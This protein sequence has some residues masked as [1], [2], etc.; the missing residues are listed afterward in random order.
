MVPRPRRRSCRSR[1]PS[2]AR[3]VHVRVHPTPSSARGGDDLKVDPGGCRAADGRLRPSP[4][5]LATARDP[6]PWTAR[7][8]RRRPGPTPPRSAF[9]AAALM[10]GSMVVTSGR[11]GPRRRGSPRDVV[12]PIS[13]TWP[14]GSPSTSLYRPWSPGC[15]PCRR[16]R[17]RAEGRRLLGGGRGRGADDQRGGPRCEGSPLRSTIAQRKSVP[18]GS[19]RSAGLTTM[20]GWR[21]R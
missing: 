1:W 15:R 3:D 4:G 11:R 2:R 16:P 14:D 8:R 9:S 7:W 21:R 20:S 10:T 5:L 12:G 6:S 17:R 19:G 18:C 13:C